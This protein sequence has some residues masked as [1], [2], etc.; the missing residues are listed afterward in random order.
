MFPMGRASVDTSVPI[1]WIIRCS[2]VV[3]RE[4]PEFST[5][6]ILGRCS[7]DRPLVDLSTKSV[8]E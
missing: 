4:L 8:A 2:S 1:W 3:P 7:L 6:G 5:V